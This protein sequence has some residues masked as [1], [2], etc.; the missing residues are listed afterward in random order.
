VSGKTAFNPGALSLTNKHKTMNNAAAR[1]G[2]AIH[3]LNKQTLFIDPCSLFIDSALY[4][5]KK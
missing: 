2:I 1:G 4:H 5:N 3:F